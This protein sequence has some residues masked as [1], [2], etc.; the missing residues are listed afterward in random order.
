MNKNWARSCNEKIKYL[1]NSFR[2]KRM[3]KN[4]TWKSGN[5]LNGNSG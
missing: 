2:T 3:T 4:G 5:Q 1:L